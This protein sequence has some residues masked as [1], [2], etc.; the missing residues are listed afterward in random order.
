M[1]LNAIKLYLCLSID[2]LVVLFAYS[3][4]ITIRYTNASHEEKKNITRIANTSRSNICPPLERIFCYRPSLHC[5][6]NKP[7]KDTDHIRSSNH[8]SII[9]PHPMPL[10]DRTNNNN[11][12][13]NASPAWASLTLK[14]NRKR[15]K[16]LS[17][18]RPVAVVVPLVCR[19]R[20]H[21]RCLA[22]ISMRTAVVAV[23]PISIDCNS[24]SSRTISITSSSS[25]FCCRPTQPAV[26][27]RKHHR[28]AIA[29]VRPVR[30]RWDVDRPQR[31]RHQHRGSQFIRR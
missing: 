22:M 9:M 18:V 3:N 5:C 2:R 8:N 4:N 25:I 6:S 29:A 19:Q 13:N 21:R 27:P 10:P 11:N 7:P 12:S 1:H 26:V 30:R 16:R 28:T 23:Q 20:R 17:V 14:W 15:S 31:Q 24:N